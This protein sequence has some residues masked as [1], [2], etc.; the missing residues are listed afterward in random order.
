MKKIG[1]VQARDSVCFNLDGEL[2]VIPNTHPQYQNILKVLENGN[3]LEAV[4]PL[5]VSVRQYIA[6][7]SDG[8]I[9]YTGGQLLFEGEPLHLS[10]VSRIIGLIRDGMNVQPLTNFLRNVL[11]NPSR[12]A[13]EEL[14]GFMEFNDLPV[15]PDGYFIAY[16]MVR[17]DFTDIHSG[18]FDNRPGA[19]PKMKRKDVDPDKNSTCSVGLHFAG[20][21]YV[22][23]GGFGSQENGNRLVAVKIHPRDVVAIPT[24][25]NNSKGRACQYLVLKELD[26]TTG[27][28]INTI[29]F[30]LYD[31]GDVDEAVDDTSASQTSQC[32]GKVVVAPKTPDDL[33]R[34]VKRKLAEDGATIASVSRDTGVSRRQVARIRDRLVGPDIT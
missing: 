8:S 23:N 28:P 32:T 12:R 3:D 14:Y 21:E 33:I 15:T 17:A 30:D 20:L 6:D 25:Y 29:G 24:D 11:E 26:W 13:Q 1:F 22:R 9:T 4:R 27:L 34:K 5:L 31:S 7:S 18:T 19:T 16:K 10:M 2:K